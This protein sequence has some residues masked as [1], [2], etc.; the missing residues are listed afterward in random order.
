MIFEI[1][2]SWSWM[3]WALLFLSVYAVFWILG[4]HVS[5]VALPHRLESSGVR[6]RYGLFTEVF[7]PYAE[8][9]GV[10]RAARKAPKPGDGMRA[11]PDEG[12]VYLAINGKTDLTVRLREPRPVRGFFSQRM[13]FTRPPTIR[14]DSSAT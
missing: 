2:I 5:L 4:F 13:R 10:E 8:I 14:S 9:S 1:L 3:R 6:L 7:V 11:A 12:A